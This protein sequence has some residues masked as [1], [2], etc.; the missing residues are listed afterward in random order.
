MAGFYGASGV[1]AHK[2]IEGNVVPYEETGV[3]VAGT[4]QAIAPDP[5]RAHLVFYNLSDSEMVIGFSSAVGASFGMLIPP[6]GGFMEM[7]LLDD[8]DAVTQ[9]VWVY[10][11][12]ATKAY[13]IYHTRRDISI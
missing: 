11:A 9:S 12:S 5:E 4:K 13:Y 2:L 7:N 3:T 8:L 1:L 10:C 6:N